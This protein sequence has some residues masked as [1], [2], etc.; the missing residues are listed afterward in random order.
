MDGFGEPWMVWLAV[1]GVAAIVELMI[2]GVFLGFVA[3]G[4]AITAILSLLFPELGLAGQLV[5]VAAWTGVAVAI[6]KRWYG[7]SNAIESSD[8]HLNDPTHRLIGARVVVAQAIAD[9]EGRVRL[10][11]SEWPAYGPDAEVGARMRV[12]GIE[13]GVLLV[14]PAAASPPPQ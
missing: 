5:S 3:I 2:P 11:D 6:G 4:A 12:T 13:G 10:G 14:E 8:P 9:G 7:G 1:A